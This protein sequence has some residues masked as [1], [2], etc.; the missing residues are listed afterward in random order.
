MAV[1]KKKVTDIAREV[2][3]EFLP[4][5]GLSLYDVEFIK[6]GP[7]R[8]LRVYIDKE[9]GYVDTGECET[10]SRFLSD[11]LDREDPI[12]D[13]Y[14]LEVS[15]PGID[16]ELKSD[17]HF[18]RYLGDEIEVSLYKGLDGKKKLTGTLISKDDEKLVVEVDGKEIAIKPE[19][20]SKVN[21]SVAI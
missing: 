12:E 14:V 11:V 18:Q 2:L 5:V 13:N 1:S 4:K 7:D 21:L 20:V 6:E 10:V 19:E 8:I 16:R 17:E 15:S 9:E 3:E